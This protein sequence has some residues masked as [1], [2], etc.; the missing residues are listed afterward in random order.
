MIILPGKRSHTQ[1]FFKQPFNGRP[2]SIAGC[3]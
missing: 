3:G 2:A 1:P